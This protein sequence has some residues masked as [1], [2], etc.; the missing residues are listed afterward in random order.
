MEEAVKITSQISKLVET[1][2]ESSQLG[3]NISQLRE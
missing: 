2:E 1:A 3:Q